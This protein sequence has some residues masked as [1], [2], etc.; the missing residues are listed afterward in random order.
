MCCVQRST[1]INSYF[2]LRLSLPLSLY[3]HLFI[4]A[5]VCVPNINVDSGFGAVPANHKAPC[6]DGEREKSHD[7]M[8]QNRERKTVSLKEKP[9]EKGKDGVTERERTRLK[10]I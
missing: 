5:S 6:L 1:S 10:E 9:V 4:C 2:S 8:D 7:S 3:L